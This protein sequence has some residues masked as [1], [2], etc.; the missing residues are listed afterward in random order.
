[1]GFRLTTMLPWANIIEAAFF[2]FWGDEVE[3]VETSSNVLINKYGWFVLMHG[4][5]E[6]I[7]KPTPSKTRIYGD[8][9]WH[10]GPTKGSLGARAG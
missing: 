7:E 1:M 5:R 8:D 9:V 4:C 2:F 6:E 3:R 10:F